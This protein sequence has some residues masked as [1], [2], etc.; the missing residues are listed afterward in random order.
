MFQIKCDKENNPQEVIDK[1]ELHA[2]ITFAPYKWADDGSFLAWQDAKVRV[3]KK[4][5]LNEFGE[6]AVVLEIPDPSI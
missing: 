2:T 1:N 3:T 5:V 4:W 6:L